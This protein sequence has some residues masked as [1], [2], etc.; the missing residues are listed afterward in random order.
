MKKILFTL[1]L[2]FICSIGYAQGYV[3]ES[4]YQPMSME[5]TMMAVRADLYR[6]QRMSELFDEYRD[7]AYSYY[8]KN[9]FNGFI[10]YSDYALSTVFTAANFIMIEV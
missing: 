6:R 7:K 4:T 5:E 9:D 8:N 2:A 3:V 1:F 10:Y